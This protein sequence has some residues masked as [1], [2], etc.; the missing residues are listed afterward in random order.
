MC[1]WKMDAP[2]GNIV[3][4]LLS[5]TFLPR[6]TPSGIWC[7]CSVRNPLMN[8]QA[9]FGYC[10]IT[11]TFI[12]ALFVSWTEL[13]TDKKANEQTDDPIIRCP[14]R[15]FQAGGIN[16]TN[17]RSSFLTLVKLKPFSCQ[18][19]K[20]QCIPLNLLPVNLIAY[21]NT[22]PFLIFYLIIYPFIL[23]ENCPKTRNSC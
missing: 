21:Q 19:I 6:P 7:L 22:K 13:R 15:T 17:G 9:K 11:H 12:I 14:R 23:M 8:L 20:V 16:C 18:G 5:P 1:L 10:I 3:K 2:G 4:Y